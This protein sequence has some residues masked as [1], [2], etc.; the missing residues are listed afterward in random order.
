MDSPTEQG[1]FQIIRNERD[2]KRTQLEKEIPEHA[3][4]IWLFDWEGFFNEL[5]LAVLVAIHHQVERELVL[6]AARVTADGRELDQEEYRKEVKNERN[7]LKKNDGWTNL[8]TKLQLNAFPSWSSSMR[9]LR[10]LVNLFK[11][12]PWIT[13]DRKLLLFLNL[14]LNVP[15]AP[16]L[17]E[18]GS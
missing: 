10:I 11:H 14:P 4:D 16:P 3:A 6:I 7:K 12:D 15:Y 5:C 9:V 8:E 18:S 2:K 17:R 13:P 1:M